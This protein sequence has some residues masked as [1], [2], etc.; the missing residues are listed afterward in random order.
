MDD[1]C[2][3]FVVDWVDAA[4]TFLHPFHNILEFESRFDV[5]IFNAKIDV[6][7]SKFVSLSPV[8]N[9]AANFKTNLFCQR[10][11]YD[12]YPFDYIASVY[13]RWKVR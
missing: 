8:T 10:T 11:R 3:V 13:G 5:Q 1:C 4:W 9:P 2:L 12:L 6:L 7:D